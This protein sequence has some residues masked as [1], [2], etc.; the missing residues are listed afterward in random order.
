MD[1]DTNVARRSR[2]FLVPSRPD[3]F[4]GTR[5][6]PERHA[7]ITNQ[8]YLGRRTAEHC[9]THSRVRLRRERNGCARIPGRCT[10]RGQDPGH[11]RAPGCDAGKAVRG[12]REAYGPDLL[13]GSEFGTT[14]ESR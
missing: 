7:E 8:E 11:G 9:G 5:T 14:H 13:P 10:R 4:R 6:R 3:G 1:T 12:E 2:S